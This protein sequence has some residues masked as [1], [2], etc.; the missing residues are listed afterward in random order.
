MQKTINYIPESDLKSIVKIT[1]S[2]C[3]GLFCLG[4]ALLIALGIIQE[5]NTQIVENTNMSSY[6]VLE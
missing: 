4:I 5:K 1:K 3:I 6:S 2:V